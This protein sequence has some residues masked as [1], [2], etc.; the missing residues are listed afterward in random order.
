[1]Y[2]SE[3]VTSIIRRA[4]SN[5]NQIIDTDIEI[6]V[7]RIKD[8]GDFST[9]VAMKLAKKLHQ[10][11]MDIARSIVEE[12]QQ[13]KPIILKAEAVKPG[14]VNLWISPNEITNVIH[15]ILSEAEEYGRVNVG[16]GK[17]VLVEFVSA[18]PT[19]P[20]HIGHCR[21]AVVG[22]S[23]ARILKFA[24][25]NVEREYY[26]NDAGAQ[27]Q[28]LGKSLRAR[29]LQLLG[30]DEPIPEDGYYGEYLV[31]IAR[32]LVAEKKDSLLH[33]NDIDFFTAFATKHILDSIK[34]DLA[35]LKVEFDHWVSESWFHRQGKVD[36]VIDELKRRNMAYEKDG[37]LW[38]KTTQFGD[39]KDRV[40]VKSNGEKTYLAPD[41]AYHKNKYE[42]HYDQ[43]INVFGGD[44]H[45]YIP[46]L[47]AAIQALG[48]DPQKLR[49]LVIQMVTLKK[50]EETMRFS[51]RKGGFITIR[52]M[53]DELGS[54]VVRFF[55]LMRTI[56]SQLVFDWELA[57]DTS[58][59][60]PVYYVQ[61]AYARSC[62]LFKKAQEEKIN[63]NLS[64]ISQ[65]NVNLL[66]LPEEQS[67]I[68]HLA[69]FPDVVR[70]AAEVL[71]PQF[72][73]A[74]LRVLTSAFHNYFT[75]GTKNPEY[76]IVLPD[77]PELTYARLA[78]VR[79]LQIV[80]RNAMSLISVSTPEKM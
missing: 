31:D 52:E 57:K 21:N 71:E 54:D 73:T 45:G 63:L 19:G 8:F 48:Y 43:L 5:L 40:L 77:N 27:M 47:K 67:I 75:A 7:P 11:P 60:N 41:I 29:Y 39:E 44:H 74:Y 51:K 56:D 37:A 55:F 33:S 53:L 23:I 42:R 22:D 38:L 30:K 62:S 13:A 15:Q 72:I 50:G 59:D 68:K 79:A 1:M 12:L 80:I 10:P 61:Y 35:D 65:A 34:T 2:L 14:F 70:R 9:N 69:L 66:T 28:N 24:G 17:R 46:R 49:C 20:L 76:R 6:E 64:G 25:F 3:K 58:I 36:E 32:A 26:F 78:L 4:I 18:N 16:N